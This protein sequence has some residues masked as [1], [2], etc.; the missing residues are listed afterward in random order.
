MS[1][2]LAAQPRVGNP[3]FGALMNTIVKLSLKNY[4]MVYRFDVV[5]RIPFDVPST[6]LF[7]Y[8]DPTY[9]IPIYWNAWGDLF[10]A[11]AI[12]KANSRQGL[13]GGYAISPFSLEFMGSSLGV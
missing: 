13:E 11:L 4:G 7:N 9:I 5:P 8:F 3:I 10:K 6:A 1:Q 12:H 2:T